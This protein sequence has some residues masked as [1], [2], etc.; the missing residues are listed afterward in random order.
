MGISFKEKLLKKKI[1]GKLTFSSET[2]SNY[3]GN[4]IKV[5]I[6]LCCGG[7]VIDIHKNS[8][9]IFINQRKIK[10]FENVIGLV[11]FGTF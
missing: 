5:L 1:T 6:F 3:K 4:W 9:T 7:I 2:E 8:I 11:E 10:L